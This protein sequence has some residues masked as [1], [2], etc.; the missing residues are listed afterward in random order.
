VTLLMVPPFIRIL[1]EVIVVVPVPVR[2]TPTPPSAQTGPNHPE[3][4]FTPRTLI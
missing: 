2:K 3:A 4:A 1:V